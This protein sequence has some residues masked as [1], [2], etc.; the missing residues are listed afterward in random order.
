MDCGSLI[1]STS[2]E[3]DMRIRMLILPSLLALLTGLSVSCRREE[4]NLA[5][6]TKRSGPCTE[7]GSGGAGSENTRDEGL[8]GEGSVLPPAVELTAEEELTAALQSGNLEEL[9]RLV[10]EQSADL[11]AVD[12]EGQTS[13]MV[14]AEYGHLSIVEFLMERSPHLLL[15]EDN[16]GRTAANYAEDSSFIADESIRTALIKLLSGEELSPEELAAEMISILLTP[17]DEQN[18]MR[19][20]ELLEKGASPGATSVVNPDV[21]VPALF[22]TMGVRTSATSPRPNLSGAPV[23]EYAEVLVRAGASL[24]VTIRLR[25][26]LTPYDLLTSRGAG[27]RYDERKDEWLALLGGTSG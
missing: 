15:L 16:Q 24:D 18:L 6:A 3:N 25:G 17:F 2:L 22:L 8:G 7:Q 19:L 27:A 23:Y 14:A 4:E 10:D 9:I 20:E 1:D 11:G 13:L 12:E 5:E 26:D 21:P